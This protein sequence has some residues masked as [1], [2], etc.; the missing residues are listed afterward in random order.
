MVK[1][2]MTITDKRRTLKIRIQDTSFG[3]EEEWI[4]RSKVQ[5]LCLGFL[6]WVFVFCRWQ[7]DNGQ[8][9]NDHHRQKT[10][11]QD[12]NPR[13][14]LWTGR[15]MNIKIQGPKLVSWILIWVFVFCRWWSLVFWPLFFVWEGDSYQEQFLMSLSLEVGRVHSNTVQFWGTGVL[16][17]LYY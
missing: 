10:N 12:K 11:T 3:L 8:K 9:T 1:R 2:L 14:K 17:V 7:K 15:R 16:V 6:S 4:S 13:H 5:S